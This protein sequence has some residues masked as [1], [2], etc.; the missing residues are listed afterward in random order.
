MKIFGD[1]GFRDIYSKGLMSEK[2]LNDFFTKLDNFLYLKKINKI[3]IGYDTR[4]TSFDIINLIQKKIKKTNSIIILKNQ[5][6]L[7]T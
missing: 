2:F 6:Q 5:S 4:K 3:I 1:D 7:H